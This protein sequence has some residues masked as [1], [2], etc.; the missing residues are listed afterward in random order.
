MKALRDGMNALRDGMNPLRD[1]MKAL[2]DRMNALRDGIHGIFRVKY[3]W[4]SRDVFCYKWRAIRTLGRT[5]TV[6]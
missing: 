1:E 4:C 6:V 3:S 5:T 2:R